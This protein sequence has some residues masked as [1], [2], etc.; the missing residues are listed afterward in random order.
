MTGSLEHILKS[1]EYRLSQQMVESRE[2]LADVIVNGS[3][4]SSRG[5]GAPSLVLLPD[6]GDSMCTTCGREF[7]PFRLAV[8]SRS[9]GRLRKPVPPALIAAQQRAES[10]RA[11][12]W[13]LLEQ[14]ASQ[15]QSSRPQQQLFSRQPRA[16]VPLATA[17]A[18]RENR[19]QSPASTQPESRM[20]TA[21]RASARSSNASSHG[22]NRSGGPPVPVAVPEAARRAAQPEH[23]G[24]HRGAE[25]EY[26]QDCDDDDP[27]LAADEAMAYEDGDED[28][29]MDPDPPPAPPQ[30]RVPARATAAPPGR[31]S[32]APPKPRA[33]PPVS[34]Q[35]SSSGGSSGFQS[36]SGSSAVGEAEE[37]A[38]ARPAEYPTGNLEDAYEAEESRQQ[39]VPCNVCGRNFNADRLDRHRAICAKATNKKRKVFGES[40][41][42]LKLQEKLE[43]ERVKENEAKAAKKALW[44]SQSEAFQN[45]MKAARA[46]KN[47]E[48][49]PADL[50]PVEDD[51]TPCPHCGRKFEAQVAE[52]HIPKC[53]TTKAKPNAVGT[54]MKRQSTSKGL[55]VGGASGAAAPAPAAAKLEPKTPVKEKEKEVALNPR[56]IIEAKKAAEKAAEV[57]SPSKPKVKKAAPPRKASPL[58]R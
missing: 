27:E 41:E 24:P 21:K 11:Q 40:A 50:V 46:I 28:D 25:F 10:I 43:A 31:P 22:S 5:S 48:P 1:M 35:P 7:D 49:P 13:A 17:T 42:R 33:P 2:H 45:A 15:P 4:T 51:R 39:M 14:A 32:S 58:A 19:A 20:P 30:S 55:T 38:A 16:G 44:K 29:Y 18:A 37:E 52:R 54:P 9:C 47:G 34:T 57:A 53:A 6:D 36:A 56:Q 23:P 26:A 12:A 8:H 3:A